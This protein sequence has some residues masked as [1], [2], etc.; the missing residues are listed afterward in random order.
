[1][2]INRAHAFTDLVLPIDAFEDR[3]LD[4]VDQERTLGAIFER[5]LKGGD[6]ERRAVSVFERLWEYDQVVF[7][8]S[9]SSCSRDQDSPDAENA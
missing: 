1:M 2:L 8:A 6:D 7:D 4:A 3:L 9:R 5:V